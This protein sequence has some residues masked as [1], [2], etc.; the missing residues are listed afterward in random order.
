MIFDL[1]RQKGRR[2]YLC[3]GFFSVFADFMHKK[4]NKNM[5]F[6]F[7]DNVDKPGYNNFSLKFNIL[8]VDNLSASF[9]HRF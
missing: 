5:H 3:G 8:S 7:V 1:L 9:F 4:M 2:I 6:Y